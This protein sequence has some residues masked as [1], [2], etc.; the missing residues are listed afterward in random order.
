MRNNDQT[1][2]QLVAW[3]DKLDE[4]QAQLQAELAD[5][6]R[7]LESV[8]TTLALLDG[9]PMP[10]AHNVAMNEPLALSRIA[11]DLDSLRGLTQ[12]EALTRIAEHNGGRLETALAK[13]ILLLAGLIKNP[14]NANNILFS[15]IQRSGRFERIEHGVYRLVGNK[16]QKP[17]SKYALEPPPT[18][19]E[20]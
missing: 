3:R 6:T 1:Y 19:S 10:L 2:I 7:K 5:V 11:L 9:N 16:P 13:K 4:R 12:I 17:E 14:K 18:I 8:S 20:Q 15:V